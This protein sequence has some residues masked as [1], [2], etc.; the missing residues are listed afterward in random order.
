MTTWREQLQRNTWLIYEKKK[1]HQGNLEGG[2]ADGEAA[3]TC[4]KPI[5]LNR[6]VPA[7]LQDAF[8]KIAEEEER[9]K[10]SKGGAPKKQSGKKVKENALK[11]AN[12]EILEKVLSARKVCATITFIDF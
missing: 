11:K 10:T 5:R 4:Y 12:K 8:N 3:E 2:S 1:N 7:K 9:K 6:K